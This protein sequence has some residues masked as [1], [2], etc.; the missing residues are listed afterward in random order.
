[1]S[2]EETRFRVETKLFAQGKI[3]TMYGELTKQAEELMLNYPWDL[4]LQNDHSNLVFDFTYVTYI[5]SAGISILIRIVKPAIKSEYQ[6]FAYGINSLQQKLFRA[7]GLTDYLMIYPD[8][9]SILQRIENI[10][11]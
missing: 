2:S 7:V 3:I 4:E 10:K 8:E 5:N 1:M 6:L 9:Y 11:I